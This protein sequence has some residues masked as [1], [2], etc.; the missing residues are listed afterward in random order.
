MAESSAT[1]R[2]R[3]GERT[4]C[5]Y[6]EQDQYP[7][8]V[9][10]SKHF[11]RHLDR[12]FQVDPELF[13]PHFQDGYCMKDIR[14]SE[15]TQ[16]A[17]RR[18][19]L[20]NG[21]HYSVRPSFVLPSMTGYTADVADA[22]F[23]AKWVP[24]WA[25]EQVYHIDSSKLYRI[26]NTIGRN[27]IVGTTIKTANIPTH[28]LADEHH[29]KCCGEKVY[30]ATTVAEG[31]V[32]G[33]EVCPSASSEDLTKGYGVFKDEALEL[34]PQYEPET[35]NT[36]GWKGT[37]GAWSAL[38]PMIA[39]LRCFLH[40][41]LSIRDRS[42]NLKEQFFDLGSRVWEVYSSE[43]CRTMSQR[44][45]RLKEWALSHLGGTALEKT[46]DL[47]AKGRFWRMWYDHPDGHATSNMLDR[48]MRGQNG[49][50]NRGQHFHGTLRS[51]NLRSRA[52]AIL[53]NYWPWSPT[54]R[55]NNNGS[56]CPA[57]RLNKKRY[58]ENWLENLLIAA[59]L[60]GT[61]NI[62]KM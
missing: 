14:T 33:A 26:I 57:E 16:L 51:S 56:A 8:I 12:L 32:L 25:L 35:V 2:T 60:H 30:I 48:L 28:L 46:L 15:K 50:F 13:P 59:S 58:A 21:E 4:I 55:K 3:Y 37:Q 61:K 44:L 22:L 62:P 40:A 9:G 38:F 23:L 49:F 45:R 17:I 47:C 10:Q 39:I 7:E 27:S 41:W 53:H 52:W 43:D 42:K 36:D 29:E 54:C 20:R 18:I 34:D 5:L 24:L 6:F 1:P 19:T 31:C 11:R